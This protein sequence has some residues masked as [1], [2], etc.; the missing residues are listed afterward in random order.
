MSNPTE[1][2]NTWVSRTADPQTTSK[3]A[4]DLG[5][6]WLLA[7]VLAG[8]GFTDA[9]K[10]RGF[11]DASLTTEPFAAEDIAGLETLAD[12]LVTAIDRKAKVLVFG[13]FDVDGITATALLYLAL[14]Q[15]GADVDWL[16]PSRIEEGYGLT[17]QVIPR[18]V[19]AAPDTVITVDC[20]ISSSDAVRTLGEQGI[21]VLVTDHHEP[22][23]HVPQD[24][25]VANPKL[26]PDGFGQ[27]LAGVGVALALVKLVGEQMNQPDLW[28]EYIDLA[29]LGTVAD[30]M[31][32]LGFNRALVRAG[33]Q[34]INNDPR[35]GIKAMVELHRNSNAY[36]SEALSATDLTYSLIPRLNA[37][38]RLGEASDAFEILVTDDFDKAHILAKRL[39]G[40]NEERRGLESELSEQAIAQAEISL[41]QG[42]KLVVVAGEGWHEGVRGIVA[43]RIANRFGVPAI[44]F[45][46]AE[47]EARG[48]GRSVGAVNLFAALEAVSDL[49][50][51]FGGHESAVGVTVLPELL[52]RFSERLES[53]LSSMPVESF[54]PP[55][56]VDAQIGLDDLDWQTV[57][58]LVMLEPFGQT[59][60]EPR[61]VTKPVSIRKQR[62]VGRA[63]SHLSFQVSD[64]TRELNAIWFNCPRIDEL[65]DASGSF[66]LVVKPEAELWR[67][68]QSLQ[69]R[70]SDAAQ[71][72]LDDRLLAAFPEARMG[73]FESQVQA[74]DLL[75]TEHSPLVLMPTGRG[76]SLI[77]QMHAARLALERRVT[78]VFVYPLRALINDQQRHLIERFSSLGIQSR[79]LCG[80][81]SGEE[82]QQT[83]ADLRSGQV[84]VL[85]TTPEF[86]LL[87]AEQIAAS[88]NVGF[89]AVDEAHHI[90]TDGRFRPAYQRLAEIPELFTTAQIMA[91][92]AT[93]DDQAADRIS[94][95]LHLDARVVD[96]TRRLNLKVS[97]R[98]NTPGRLQQTI[99]VVKLGEPCVVYT[100][101][102]DSARFLVRDLR[103]ALPE[104]ALAI[105]F[106]HGG[107]DRALR[108]KLE[109]GFFDGSVNCLVTTSAFG[110]GVNIADIRNLVVYHPP[111]SREQLN[112]LSGRAGRDGQP[113]TIHLLFADDDLKDNRK[114]LQNALPDHDK[115]STLY[116]Y[117]RGLERDG[118]E[119]R[120]SDD[121]LAEVV[122]RQV[123][124][125]MRLTKGAMS[126][127]QV[128]MA[129][130]V[131]EQL[132]LIQMNRSGY[133]RVIEL[134]PDQSKVELSSAS[135]YLEAYDEI[136]GFDAFS[137]WLR[138]AD[139]AKIEHLIQGPIVPGSA[140]AKPD[141]ELL[142]GFEADQMSIRSSLAG[143]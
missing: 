101:S 44:V 82:R 10:A 98:R 42:G 109:R 124:A 60:P 61:F 77:F 116:R 125:S 74:L 90:A 102:R 70:V 43:S 96:R 113:S 68:T 97:D 5:V 26:D 53:Q 117:L 106:Y 142:S 17:T 107:L 92:T 37:P 91:A 134:N 80:Q 32:L 129:L 103:K 18:I 16:I 89:I 2:G 100:Y 7:R 73:L 9:D 99:D 139:A 35:L 55:V 112:Q 3:L 78:S 56:M 132:G 104:Q 25:C 94:R 45:T 29:T 93:A 22:G 6:G 48:S 1:T 121:S 72:S 127:S 143:E 54:H 46:L 118:I 122:N 131:F 62:L 69:L 41:K 27:D 63:K 83:Y 14:R 133:N 40:L 20:G 19:A 136:A 58:E 105:D 52:G 123:D 114:L 64:G 36:L 15:L 49:T 75:A 135:L 138:A 119:I 34:K 57:Q 86:L 126:S 79:V 51:R 30:M 111:F 85:L 12:A 76:K 95:E 128:N 110:E 115:L 66:E 137:E 84:S 21:E 39:M 50:L 31:P 47:G 108:Q 24:V 8:R 23:D 11:L 33:L 88:T 141:G 28:L 59:N 67:G 81:S 130:R 65:V 87:H 140:S 38:G 4:F 71:A 13:D 120:F